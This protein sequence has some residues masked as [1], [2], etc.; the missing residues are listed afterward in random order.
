LYRGSGVKRA[1]FA[2][3]DAPPVDGLRR[4]ARRVAASAWHQRVAA[5]A[6]GNGG[7]G[8]SDSAGGNM[9]MAS[10]SISSVHQHQRC[11]GCILPVG[12][13]RQAADGVSASNLGMENIKRRGETIKGESVL[14]IG[15]A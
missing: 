2:A 1:L 3:A 13:T 11:I 6:A 4:G 7:D 15:G 9:G 14:A 12:V 5:A 8:N 10:S